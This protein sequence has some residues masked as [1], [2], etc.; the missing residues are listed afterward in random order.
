M[1][2]RSGINPERFTDEG[3]MPGPVEADQTPPMSDETVSL[4]PAPQPM[5]PLGPASPGT[6]ATEEWESGE[7]DTEYGLKVVTSTAPG[8]SA[9]TGIVQDDATGEPIV[10]ATVTMRCQIFRT[11]VTTTS[12]SGG[13][14]AFIDLPVNTYTLTVTAPG[15]GSFSLFGNYEADSQYQVTVALTLTAQVETESTAAETATEY[16]NDVDVRPRTTMPQ[17][18][19]SCQEPPWL[20]R[21][22]VLLSRRD[23]SGAASTHA[24]PF[25]TRG[26]GS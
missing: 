8:T 21:L 9:L 19:Y 6:Y 10:G 24:S 18:P 16:S 26:S 4:A 3:D 7:T 12:D 23:L 11:I 5:S 17:V 20:V 14:F 2:W 13:A 22:F 25:A 1:L 15:Y